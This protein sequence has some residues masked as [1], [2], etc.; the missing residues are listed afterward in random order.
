VDCLKTVYAETQNISY[1]IL[2]VDN[3]SGD[4][5][6]AIIQA[7][8][9]AVRWIQ[10]SYNTGFAR[11][12]NEAIRQSRGEVVLLLNSD[13]LIEGG[14]IAGCCRELAAS[15]YIACGYST[16]SRPLASDLW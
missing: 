3:A 8:Y 15:P 7:A 1:E 14:A 9:P 5:S 10:M 4:G 11:A 12:N 16:Q 6:Q 2:I 13:T